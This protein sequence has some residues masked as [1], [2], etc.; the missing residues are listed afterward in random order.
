MH[1]RPP[2]WGTPALPLRSRVSP[3]GIPRRRPPTR[4]RA[5]AWPTPRMVNACPV[6][7]VSCIP[8]GDTEKTATNQ[9]QSSCMAASFAAKPLGA[10]GDLT[11]HQEEPE[12]AEHH[13]DPRETQGG[14]GR[15]AGVH[16]G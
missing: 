10:V 3:Q 13:E 14:E 12:D 11:T 15:I 2:G 7:E 1:G 4:T 8:A 6:T 5:H 9:N 16:E